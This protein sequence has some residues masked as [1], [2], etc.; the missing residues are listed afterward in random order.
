MSYFDEVRLH[1]YGGIRA[2]NGCA[3]SANY[4]NSYDE[5]KGGKHPRKDQATRTYPPRNG[6]TIF[7]DPLNI[8]DGGFR[9]GTKFC[10]EDLD[11]MLMN[12]AFVDGTL[13]MDKKGLWEVYTYINYRGAQR[14][15]KRRIV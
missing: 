3:Y 8:A 9:N 10:K 5:R 4:I 12:C 11:A 13:I 6:T 14:Q 15:K 7:N 1:S 2:R